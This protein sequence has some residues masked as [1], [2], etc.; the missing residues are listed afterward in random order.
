MACLHRSGA[1]DYRGRFSFCA[2]EHLSPSL[3]LL[4]VRCRSSFTGPL[5][6]DNMAP[7]A[8][9]ND[10]SDHGVRYGKCEESGVMV[11]LVGGGHHNED[12]M[13]PSEDVAESFCPAAAISFLSGAFSSGSPILGLRERHA[14]GRVEMRKSDG[15]VHTSSPHVRWATTMPEKLKTAEVRSRFS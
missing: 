6:C 7:L 10:T 13:L 8:R 4:L 9:A 2:E 5:T 15:L 12:K 1:G 3:L 14:W 11:R